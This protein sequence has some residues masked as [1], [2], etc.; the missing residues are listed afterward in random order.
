MSRDVADRPP[1][2]TT[3]EKLREALGDV[4]GALESVGAL[5]VA[6]GHEAFERQMLG[7]VIWPER[8]PAMKEP[9]IN[10]APV[11]QKAGEGRTPTA[12]DFRR[13]PALGGVGSEL[14][15][16]LAFK[17][18]GNAVEIGTARADLKPGLFQYGGIG[19]VAITETTRETL[20]NWLLTDR[21]ARP[22]KGGGH[23]GTGRNLSK[24]S[25][26]G[27]TAVRADFARKLAFVWNGERT[28]L[29]QAAYPRP[30]IGY[31]DETHANVEEKMDEWLRGAVA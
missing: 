30:F 10:L 24:K 19:R 5:V 26:A 23:L 29:V 21:G 27:S 12:D 22:V 28:E 1:I 16:S 31:T 14:A 7:D 11:V 13:R 2:R 9:F 4:S 8:Y 15:Q 3:P 18:A 6:Q 17:V 25:V 20:S